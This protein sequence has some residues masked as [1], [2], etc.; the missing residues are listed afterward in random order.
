MASDNESAKIFCLKLGHD[1]EPT[2]DPRFVKC[3]TCGA[4]LPA[5]DQDGD[6][7]KENA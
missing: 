4:V 2:D 7:K 1:P 5:P 3:K 6:S